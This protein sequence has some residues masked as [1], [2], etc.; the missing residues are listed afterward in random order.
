MTFAKE[1]KD[2]GQR[3]R[4]REIVRQLLSRAILFGETMIVHAVRKQ[5][6]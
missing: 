3:A 2:T 5:A 6:G 1:E 4:N